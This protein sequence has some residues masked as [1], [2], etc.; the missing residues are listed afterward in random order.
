MTR[1]WQ[2]K[3]D[4]ETMARTW[5]LAKPHGETMM[6]SAMMTKPEND[7]NGGAN[8]EDD[9]NDDTENGD[10]QIDRRASSRFGHHRLIIAIFLILFLSSLPLSALFWSCHLGPL[11]TSFWFRP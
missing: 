10:R 1:R 7:E 2:R 8:D 6:R 11:L 5:I 4:D 9:E 3:Q